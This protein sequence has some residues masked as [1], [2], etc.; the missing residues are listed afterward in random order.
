MFYN[1]HNMTT[2]RD[3]NVKARKRSNTNRRSEVKRKENWKGKLRSYN[4]NLW[5]QMFWK[6]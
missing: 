4:N 1:R 5:N 2:Y 6:E 3:W